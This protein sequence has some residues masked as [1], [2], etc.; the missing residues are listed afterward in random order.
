[1]PD[2]KT[3]KFVIQNPDTKKITDTPNLSIEEGTEIKFFGDV[4]KEYEKKIKITD[5]TDDPIVIDPTTWA[6]LKKAASSDGD[7]RELS[8]MDYEYAK[9]YDTGDVE[10]NMQELN[11][12]L[13]KE[14][15]KFKVEGFVAN[16][17]TITFEAENEKNGYKR[18]L[19]VKFPKQ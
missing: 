4:G 5:K 1:M 7:K 17:S 19:S 6:M 12:L 2:F 15:S 11:D 13:K 16:K 14:G 8:E 10:V 18:S 9:R 3:V